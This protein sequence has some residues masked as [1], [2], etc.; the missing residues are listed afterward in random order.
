ML[1]LF[2]CFTDR[3]KYQFPGHSVNR[4][5]EKQSGKKFWTIPYECDKGCLCVEVEMTVVRG[6]GLI[7]R[8]SS[9]GCKIGSVHE[10]SGLLERS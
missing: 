5:Q 4:K 8:E 1:K 2:W 6:P 9:L 7:P 3:T 10:K